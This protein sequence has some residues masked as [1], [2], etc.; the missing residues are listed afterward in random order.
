LGELTQRVK[1]LS[2]LICVILCSIAECRY[3]WNLL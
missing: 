2:I 3:Y 1:S